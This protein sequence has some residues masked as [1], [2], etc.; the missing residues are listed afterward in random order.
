MVRFM[1]NVPS[2]GLLGLCALAF[3][4]AIA[5]DGARPGD[6][7]TVL[8][9]SAVAPAG[10]PALSR[11]CRSRWIAGDKFRRPLRGLR[12]AIRAGRQPKVLAIGSSSTVGTGAS[13]PANAYTAK[14]AQD[15]DQ[16]FKGV[17][18]DVEA[19]GIG[20]EMAEGQSAR[21][22]ATVAEVKPDLVLWQVGTN[23]AINHVDLLSFKRCLKRT[24]AML[25]AANIDVMLVDPQYSDELA[26]DAF[27]GDVVTAI[28]EVAAENHVLLVD[29]FEA[30]RELSQAHGETLYLAGDHLHLNDEGHK[31]MAEQLAR[32]IVTG[33]LQANGE[34]A[35]ISGK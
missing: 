31:C 6:G 9:L 18:F 8:A 3:N 28:A 30:M 5:G 27:Y 13:Q 26:K 4:P 2:W 12:R 19:R 33:V 14:L 15:L 20:G 16:D 22:L 35:E 23:D 24:L 10:P 1:K 29:R 11:D 34:T 17:A 32:A 21:M 25:A 7:L